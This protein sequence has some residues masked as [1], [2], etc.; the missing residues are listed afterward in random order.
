MTK[1]PHN[2]PAKNV[3]VSPESAGW[4]PY[5][6]GCYYKEIKQR[7]FFIK[8]TAIAIHARFFKYTME[9]LEIQYECD[10]LSY[11][12]CRVKIVKRLDMLIKCNKS[13]AKTP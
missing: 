9:C 8:C 6:N 13:L 2:I 10:S 3:M 4:T 12:S 11:D 7:G 1:R 5:D